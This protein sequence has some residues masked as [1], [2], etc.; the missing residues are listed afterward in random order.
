MF[1]AVVPAGDPDTVC[2]IA[3]VDFDELAGNAERHIKLLRLEIGSPFVFELGG[4]GAQRCVRDGAASADNDLF[5]AV[6]CFK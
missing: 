4:D 6:P 1:A 3:L 2:V 5:G